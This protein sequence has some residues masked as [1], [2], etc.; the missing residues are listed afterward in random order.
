VHAGEQL[1]WVR[2]NDHLPR[3]AQTPIEGSPL[4]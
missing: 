2:L 1:P 3:Y 4:G